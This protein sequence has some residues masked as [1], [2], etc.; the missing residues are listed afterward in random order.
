MMPNTIFVVF[1]TGIFALCI[2][3]FL[4]AMWQHDADKAKLEQSRFGEGYVSGKAFCAN[5][6]Y[7]WDCLS[8][9]VQRDA[10]IWAKEHAKVGQ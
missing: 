10:K 2:G 5:N 7:E 8:P 6:P 4:G 3:M 9:D 1:M